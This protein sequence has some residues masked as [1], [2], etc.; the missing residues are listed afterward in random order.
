[1]DPSWTQSIHG[2]RKPADSAEIAAAITNSLGA[3]VLLNNTANYFDGPSVAQG[4]SGTWWASGT[5]TLND[6]AGNAN[7]LCKLWDGTTVIA[8]AEDTKTTSQFGVIALSGYLASPAANIRISCKD[9]S[10]TSGKIL[11]NATGNS[12]DSTLS[13]HRIQ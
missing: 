1:M 13:V 8:S 6:T 4:T 10:L 5:V 7:F 12:K 2:P 11:F 3:D 9:G